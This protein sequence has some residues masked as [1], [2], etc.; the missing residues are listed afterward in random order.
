MNPFNFLGNYIQR[1]MPYIQEYGNALLSPFTGQGLG[2]Q[3][4]GGSGLFGYNEDGS[5]RSMGGAL[6]YIGQSAQERQ[7]A[8]EEARRYLR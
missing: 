3:P 4:L 7:K 8:I 5:P 2:G 6:E 1:T